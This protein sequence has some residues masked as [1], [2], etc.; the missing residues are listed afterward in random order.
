MQDLDVSTRRLSLLAD[1]LPLAVA[2]LDAELWF[3]FVN[4]DFERRFGRPDPD[5][6][7]VR[8]F[9][10]I[11]SPRIDRALNQVVRERET[12]EIAIF[13]GDSG[14]ASPGLHL[15]VVPD[16]ADHAVRAVFLIFWTSDESGAQAESETAY[17]DRIVHLQRLAKLGEIAAGLA[18]EVRQPI[19][20]ITNYADAMSRMLDSGAPSERFKA[21]AHSIRAQAGRASHISTQARELVGD[22]QE[23]FRSCDLLQVIYNSIEMTEREARAAGAT[24]RFSARSSMLPCLGHP[25]QLEQILVNLISNAIEAV[26]NRYERV[27]HINAEVI[28]NELV[29]IRVADSGP[30]VAPEDLHTIFAAFR[31]G[32]RGWGW[33]CLSAGRSPSITVANFGSIR[34]AN[35]APASC[36]IC[37]YGTRRPIRRIGARRA[38]SA[39]SHSERALRYGVIAQRPSDFRLWPGS[40]H[41]RCCRPSSTVAADDRSP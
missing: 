40:P 15:K 20:A 22:R 2:Y 16:V 3:K 14:Q 8:F 41:A 1:S 30:G 33:D 34:S 28:Q 31:S 6:E 23:M 10:H 37:R 9:E 11:C 17:R 29:R 27:V 5:Q 36:S 38:D 4:R 18:H 21:L 7:A 35:P 26:S 32:V 12:T 13:F 19:S 24:V 39:A 25:A